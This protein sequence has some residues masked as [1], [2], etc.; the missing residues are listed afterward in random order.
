MAALFLFFLLVVATFF[1]VRQ[2]YPEVMSNESFVSAPVDMQQ[3]EQSVSPQEGTSQLRQQVVELQRRSQVDKET[4]RLT[5]EELRGLQDERLRLEGEV[6]RLR[7]L[8]EPG[9]SKNKLRIQHFRLHRMQRADRY[10]YLFTVSKVTESS[11][12][13]AGRIWVTVYGNQGGSQS[14]LPLKSVTTSSIESLKMRFRQFQKVEG[15]LQLPQGFEPLS[16]TI[17][18]R[19]E[20][21]KIAPVKSKFDW[22]VTG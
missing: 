8:V 7:G 22:V 16:V 10:R 6:A 14:S 21:G 17:E 5:K 2:W 1:S 12:Y 9:S 3:E 15:V 20:S 13:V 18:V 11:N 19:P 4:L